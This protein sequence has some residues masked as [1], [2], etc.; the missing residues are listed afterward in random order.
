MAKV[1]TMGYPLSG[2]SSKIAKFKHF[3][4]IVGKVT[5]KT[6]TKSGTFIYK[7]ALSDGT[8]IGS[9]YATKL[10]VDVGDILEIRAGE[11]KTTE[12]K[13]TW[14]NPRV[15]SKKPDGTSLTTPEQARAMAKARRTQAESSEDGELYD[16]DTL[17]L[18]IP[19]VNLL[20]PNELEEAKGSDGEGET[21]GEAASRFFGD[22]WYKLFPK[23]GK[24]DFV[25]HAHWRGL[26]DD[27]VDLSH[28]ELLKTN[29]SVHEDIR[30]RYSSDNLFGWTVFS[31]DVSEV[32]DAKG[33][34]VIGLSSDES[35]QVAP[36]LQ[37]PLSW[38]YVAR[39]KPLVSAPGEVGATA[40]ASAKF[41]VLD[42]GTYR[43][44]V[45][46]EHFHE[47]F[48]DGDRLK[49]RYIVQY[50]PIGGRRI[51]ILKKPKDQTPYAETHDKDRIIDELKSKGQKYLV[52]GSPKSKPELITI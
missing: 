50:A 51:W 43:I 22:N 41:F 47:Y 14:D 3:R 9:T 2:H 6:K 33:S 45:L 16:K 36:K 20:V 7:I 38:L 13:L 37:M 21:R 39:K 25:L 49:G 29:N 10:D 30:L 44:G 40:H 8:E 28:E 26:K 1:A 4:E 42:W 24:S 32:R 15:F 12:G 46:R 48:F 27:E 18:V 5:D 34:R 11:V 23:S 17:E 19:N 31:G 52:W 35:L